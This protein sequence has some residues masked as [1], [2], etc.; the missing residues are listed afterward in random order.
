MRITG[1]IICTLLL[2]ACRF[3]GAHAQQT[4]LKTNVLYWGATTPNVGFEVALGKKT[5][6]DIVG[7][8]NPWTFDNNRKIQHWTV[9]PEL[10]LW[11]CEAF[12]GGFFG[13]HA[14]YGWYNAGGV[15]LPLGILPGLKEHRYEG[16]LTG[17]GVSYGYQWYLGPHWNLE[18]TFGFGYLYLNYDKY[19]CHQCG[20]FLG[21]DKK[22]YFGPT[23][24]GL[25]FV[26]LI[27]TKK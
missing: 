1:K 12:D 15:D 4:A 22:H 27:K 21:R 3:T 5:T 26:Y 18:A 16:W 14:T 6:L 13:F 19:Q 23:R 17:V 25:S 11:N 20:D 2:I 8:C 9:Q 7:T 24:V 10:R